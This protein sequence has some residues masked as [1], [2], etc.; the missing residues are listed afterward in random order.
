M[1][2]LLEVLQLSADYLQKKGGQN[3]RRQAEELLCDFLGCSRIKLYSSFDRP[4]TE[5]ELTLFRERLQR[6]GEGEPAAYIH[7]GVQFYGCSLTVNPNVLIPRQETEILVSKVV[8]SLENEPLEGKRLWDL[9]CGSG[10]IGVAL[11][12]RLPQL[13]VSLADL[14]GEALEVAGENARRNGVGVQLLQGDLLAPFAGEK[15]DYILC[16][17]PYVSEVEYAALDREVVAHEPRMALVSGPGGLEFYKRLAAELPPYLN[18]GA[19]GWLEIGSGQGEGVSKIF[20]GYRTLCEKDWAGHDRF[21]T[22]SLE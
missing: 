11:K 19:K 10:C 4:L 21:F 12:K 14:S 17:P 20:K 1:K 13:D 8:E 7:G 9:C 16:N 2:T 18:P 5:A 22:F 3:G 6:R 15:A